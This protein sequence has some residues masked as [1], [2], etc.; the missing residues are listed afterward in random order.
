MMFQHHI[1]IYDGI[2]E[3]MQTGV[4]NAQ[5]YDVLPNV[6]LASLCGDDVTS[7]VTLRPIVARSGYLTVYFEANTDYRP[8]ELAPYFFDRE[9]LGA[10]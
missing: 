3:F 7:N 6:L 10:L 2:P 5:Q 4:I 8:S 9:R 1:Y